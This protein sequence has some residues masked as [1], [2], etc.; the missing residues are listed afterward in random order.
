MT[1][2][3]WREIRVMIEQDIVDGVMAPGARL[4]TEQALAELYDTGRHTVRRAIAS[5]AKTGHV[6]VEQGRG[7]FVHPR[8]RIEYAISRRTR[9]GRNMGSQG[10]EVTGELINSE[11]LAAD[12]LVAQHLKIELGA[13]V[14]VTQRLA[15]ADGVPLSFGAIYH[16]IS[17]FPDFSEQRQELGSVSA[18]YAAHGITDYVRAQTEIKARAARPEEA[19]RLKQHPEMPVLIVRATD[20]EPDGRPLSFSE[21]I[22][23]AARVKFTI[24]NEDF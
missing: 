15:Y 13:P 1:K 21:V 8:P 6:S 12:D 4:P 23:S 11:K 9:M 16:D 17:R 2:E 10:I 3:R 18:V 24:S 14:L 19:Q 5:L 22:W 20:T 7:T